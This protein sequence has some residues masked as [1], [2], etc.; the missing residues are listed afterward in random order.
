MKFSSKIKAWVLLKAF[1]TRE[2]ESMMKIFNSYICNKL[3][4]SWLIWNPDKKGEIDKKE[5]IQRDFTNEIRGLEGE[6]N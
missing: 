5:R 4:Y 3:D 2:A 6:E 1:K